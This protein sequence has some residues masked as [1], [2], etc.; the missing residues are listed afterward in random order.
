MKKTKHKQNKKPTSVNGTVKLKKIFLKNQKQN[1]V[2]SFSQ[3]QTFVEGEHKG[4]GKRS[5]HSKSEVKNV[6][7]NS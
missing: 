7:Q 4:K 6:P 1:P 3:L 2:I 5:K